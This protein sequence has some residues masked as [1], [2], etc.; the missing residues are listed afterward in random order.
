MHQLEENFAKNK[1]EKD[2]RIGYIS[3]GPVPA[4]V[5]SVTLKEAEPCRDRRPGTAMGAQ[6][7]LCK[8]CVET[9]PA[10]ELREGLLGYPSSSEGAKPATLWDVKHDLTFSF[11]V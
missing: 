11:L 10:S 2:E 5:H 6:R 8:G 7:G 4:A 9:G 3:G 1:R